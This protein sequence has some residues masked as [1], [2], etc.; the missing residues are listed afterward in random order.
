MSK[1]LKQLTKS[2]V[3]KLHKLKIGGASY[4]KFLDIAIGSNKNTLTQL[5]NYLD[6]YKGKFT[7]QSFKYF[8]SPSKQLKQNKEYDE[9]HQNPIKGFQNYEFDS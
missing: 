6:T 5:N 3:E 7:V 1:I 4:S 2:A 8:K 9:K